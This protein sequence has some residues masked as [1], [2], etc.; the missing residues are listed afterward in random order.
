MRKSIVS[1]CVAL[2]LCVSNVGLCQE[3]A[4]V[5]LDR[6]AAVKAFQQLLENAKSGLK[7]PEAKTKAASTGKFAAVASVDVPSVGGGAT[8]AGVDNAI[9]VWFE[10]G[11][12]RYVN[13]RAYRWAPGEVFY[14]HVQ[15]AVPVY[16]V[17]Y[18]NYT[19]GLPSKRVYPDARFP[20]SYQPMMPGVSTRLPV[21]FQMDTNFR[22]ELMSIVVSRADWDGI[23]ADVPQAASASVAVAYA[24]ANSS[25]GEAIA[26][27][28]VMKSAGIN[29]EDVE[30][31]GDGVL[32]KFAVINGAGIQ[33][34]GYEADGVKCRRVRYRCSYPIY[35]R[36]VHYVSFSNRVT[37]YVN[38]TNVTNINYINYR[39]CY[40]NID[41]VAFYLF[42]DNGIGQYQIALNK[43]S[44]NWGWGWTSRTN[45]N[46]NV[47]VNTY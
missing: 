5:E 1:F 24:S 34:S 7:A 4:E 42:S 17:L 28:G 13:P 30:I 2:L 6:D 36:P 3:A 19:N 15:S 44:P 25:S 32:K 39:G 21:A 37:N 9:R 10:L 12:G 18:Q 47:N 33:D 31:K 43:I 26:F 38:V 22:P 40:T 14:V 16:V 20:D 27:A 45:V 8:I 41:D 35:V 11:D 46:V 23:R 29:S